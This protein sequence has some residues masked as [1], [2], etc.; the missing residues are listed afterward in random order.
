MRK[1][2]DVL[3][4]LFLKFETIV[5]ASRNNSCLK[6][7][8][9]RFNLGKPFLFSLL[10]LKRESW[11][12][13]ILNWLN[14]CQPY[15][16]WPVRVSK[17]RFTEKKVAFEKCCGELTAVELDLYSPFINLLNKKVQLLIL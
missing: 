17:I 4:H 12:Q 11:L 9:F 14:T 2:G 3:M 1:V 10:G 13:P 16:N 15:T 8:P 7:L 5:R 6:W